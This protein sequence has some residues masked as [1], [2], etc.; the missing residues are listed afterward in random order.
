MIQVRLMEQK[1]KSVLPPSKCLLYKEARQGVTKVVVTVLWLPCTEDWVEQQLA[2]VARA[3]IR[4]DDAVL[5][6]PWRPNTQYAIR[7]VQTHS[8]QF[9]YHRP[10]TQYAIHNAQTHSQRF[11]YH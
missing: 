2:A 11:V 1:P 3:A 9:V 10:D 8:Q 6:E 4:S 5:A 7:N